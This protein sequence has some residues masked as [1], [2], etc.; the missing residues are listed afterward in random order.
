VRAVDKNL[1]P[2]IAD[3]IQQAD[4]AL[5]AG[6]FSVINKDMLPPSGDKRDY[7]SLAPYWWPNPAKP[8]GLP[9][10]RR[11]GERN[12]EIHKLRNRLDLG[13]MVDAVEILTLAYYFTEDEK[14]ASRA[15]LLIRHWFLDPVAGM[16]PN[17]KYGQAI[18]GVNEGRGEGLIETR[19]LTRVIDSI[20]LLAGSPAWL[21]KDQQGSEEWFSKFLDWMLTSELGRD[22]ANSENNH[23]TFYD[24]QAACYALF[25]GKRDVARKI[26]QTVGERRIAVQI[27]RNGSQ[28]LELKR[29]KAW[30]YSVG[31]LAGLMALARLGEHVDVDLW[32]YET[33]DGRG[34]RKALDFLAPF[35][36]GE[37]AWPHQQINGF[38]PDIF[39]PMLRLAAAKYPNGPY[40]VML[41][42][43]PSRSATAGAL[44]TSPIEPIKDLHR[45]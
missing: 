37:R 19:T 38:S 34:I 43:L 3:L 12:P 6:P 31:N 40:T 35:G 2:A 1:A 16:N 33:K 10:I 36:V 11:D 24:V 29:T 18:R 8:D 39:Y 27:A 17:L 20:G 30:S 25:I 32:R 14:Y 22:E 28:P 42:K 23:G 9:Y 21:A 5:T 7:M 26:L 4:R 15:A 45:L 41:A 13:E 44:W